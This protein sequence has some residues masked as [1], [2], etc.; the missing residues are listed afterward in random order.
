MKLDELS[1]AQA[2]RYVLLQS[3]KIFSYLEHFL[4]QRR[5][6]HHGQV[7]QNV[8]NKWVVEEFP[9]WLQQQVPI[10]EKH[11]C[12][13]E[14]VALARGPNSYAKRY[15]A[16]MINGFKFHTK[17]QEIYRKTQ[18][19]GVV[20][21]VKEG[22]EENIVKKYYG[23]IIDI[24]ELDYYGKGNVVIF[25]CDWVNI[26]S[27]SGLKKDKYGLPLVSFSR[28]IHTGEALKDDP[29]VLS[30][31]AKQVFYVQD[32]KESEWMHIVETK[33]RDL[34]DMG[35]NLEEGFI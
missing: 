1:L 2:H 18:N 14:T 17:D 30:T 13:E 32:G 20:V 35:S 21:E 12:D 31:N 9:G 19:S 33:P 8:E 25:R 5:N 24:Y 3:P 26:N 27:S 29:F 11:H 22:D 15:K 16:F 7:N 4:K 6:M 10:M 23:S 34:Y 28:L